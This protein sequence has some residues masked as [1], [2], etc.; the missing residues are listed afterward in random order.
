MQ[1]LDKTVAI[2]SRKKIKFDSMNNDGGGKSTYFWL[3][4]N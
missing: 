1:F 4:N 3:T 2:Y